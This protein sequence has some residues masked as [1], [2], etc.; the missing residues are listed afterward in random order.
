MSILIKNALLDGK[1]QDIYI[2]DNRI[3]TIGSAIRQK[4]EH[5]IDGTNKAAIPSFF[6]GHTHAAMTLFRGWADDMPLQE[7]LETKIW[8]TEAKLTEQDVYIGARL[9][10]LEMIRSGT[11]FFNDMYL[12]WHGTARAARDMGIRAHI[13]DVFFDFC[14]QKKAAGEIQK[15]REI[16]QDSKKYPDTVGFS[17]GPHAIYSVSKESLLWHKEFA[18]EN[19][20]LIHMHLS[21]TRKEVD[22]CIKQHGK[23]PA[24]YLEEIGFLGPNV[25]ACHS[26]WL[27]KKEIAILANHKVKVAHNPTS[28][29]KLSVGEAIRYKELRAAGVTVCLGTDGC[30]SNNNLD[31]L[32]EMKIAALLQKHATNEPTAMAARETFEMATINGAKAFGI[33]AGEIAVGKLADL[34]LIDL[35]RPEL[36]PHHDLISNLVYSANGYCVDTTI[37]NGKIIM[38]NRK[39]EGEEK[40]MEEAERAAKKLMTK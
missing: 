27:D 8:Q 5:E 24:E 30:A 15:N 11:T 14:D 25:I 18:D 36:V 40:I 6:N 1:N 32:E 23:R 34:L 21:E 22:D 4:A 28:N 26:V 37:C 20:L 38:Q 9:A 35:K 7:W 33:D 17:L 19:K 10:C 13:S 12:H 31:M 16:F 3:T 29:M 2:E 39:V